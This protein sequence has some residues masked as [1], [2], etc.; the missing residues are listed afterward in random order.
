MNTG[1]GRLGGLRRNIIIHS[2]L[3]CN[4]L[5]SMQCIHWDALCNV[6]YTAL[7]HCRM[8]LYWTDALWGDKSSVT[9]DT[10]QNSIRESSQNNGHSGSLLLSYKYYQEA[11]L[12]NSNTYVVVRSQEQS[13]CSSEQWTLQYSPTLCTGF[14]QGKLQMKQRASVFCFIRR[15]PHCQTDTVGLFWSGQKQFNW[16]KWGDSMQ[17]VNVQCNQCNTNQHFIYALRDER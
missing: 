4:A 10:N 7:L 8:A 2:P 17:W 5:Y 13:Y 12:I 1:F 11:I 3:H 9:E 16:A 14:T 15:L 6:F